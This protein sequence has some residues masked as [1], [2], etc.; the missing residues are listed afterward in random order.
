[1]QVTWSDIDSNVIEASNLINNKY[2]QQYYLAFIT[3]VGFDHDNDIDCNGDFDDN[4]FI[5][6]NWCEEYHFLFDNCIKV[7]A[8]YEQ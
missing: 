6:E 8:T 3:S 5:L 1:M 2:N 4:A 7:I